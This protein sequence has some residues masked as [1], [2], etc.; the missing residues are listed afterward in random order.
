MK[1]LRF[2]HVNAF[3]NTS[4]CNLNHISVGVRFHRPGCDNLKLMGI[5]R[6][7]WLGNGKARDCISF[8][9]KRGRLPLNPAAPKD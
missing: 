6:A 2:V 5:G 1:A 4:M 7:A 3:H 9:G 8:F